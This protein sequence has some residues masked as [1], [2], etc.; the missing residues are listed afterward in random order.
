[1]SSLIVQVVRIDEVLPHPDPAAERI[2]VAVVKGWRT[3]IPKVDDGAGNLVPK[4]SAGDEVIYVP[5]DAV[6]PPEVAEHWGVTKYLGS[7]GRVKAANLRG[8]MSY[9]FIADVEDVY[10]EGFI[11]GERIWRTDPNWLTTKWRPEVGDDVAWF[12]S[13]E[14]WEP[15]ENF[16]SANLEPE[17][18]AFR[19]YTDIELYENFPHMIEDGDEIVVT[20][21]IHGTNCRVGMLRSPQEGAEPLLVCG[22]HNAQ[23]RQDVDSFYLVPLRDPKV[24]AL[25]RVTY[26]ATPDVHAVVL[27]G[28]VYGWVQSLRYGHRKGHASFRAF[29]ISVDGNFLDWDDVVEACGEAGVQM[30]PVLYRGPFDGATLIELSNG[31]TVVGGDHLREGVVCHPVVER[32]NEEGNRVMVKRIS[33]QYRLKQDRISDSH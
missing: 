15:G 29:D 22:T 3:V 14:K 16:D 27:F 30:V 11:K 24:V 31:P 21:K 1:M 17:N 23:V 19:Q 32:R 4:Y 20:E 2:A 12:Y 18:P 10:G 8:E 5:P 25:L 33:D 7:E 9:G 6:L 13:I 26:D 28:E